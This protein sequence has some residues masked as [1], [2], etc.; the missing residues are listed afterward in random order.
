M[1]SSDD[2]SRVRWLAFFCV[3]LCA[4]AALAF[5]MWHIC[6][7]PAELRVSARHVRLAV[8][9]GIAAALI[10]IAGAVLVGRA[11]SDL[12]L[13]PAVSYLVALTY[14]VWWV[15]IPLHWLYS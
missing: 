8:A 9:S 11:L 13:A 3:A 4:A 6:V 2:R 12:I 14:L 7:A 10:P 5:G 15:G 1:N